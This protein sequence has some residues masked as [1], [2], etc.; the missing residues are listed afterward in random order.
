MSKTT[1]IDPRSSCE[2]GYIKNPNPSPVTFSWRPG[3]EAWIVYDCWCVAYVKIKAICTTPNGS[4]VTID[5][6]GETHCVSPDILF[7][8][9]ED[10]ANTLLAARKEAE[11]APQ[12]EPMPEHKTLTSI[13]Y[14]RMILEH[15]I[16][17][18]IC[19]AVAVLSEHGRLSDMSTANMKNYLDMAENLILLMKAYDDEGFSLYDM[20]DAILHEISWKMPGVWL[21]LRNAMQQGEQEKKEAFKQVIRYT[22]VVHHIKG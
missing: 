21:M 11:S 13:D 9:C 22:Q 4:T 3:D 20:L 14:A 7:I 5:D 1:N 6:D 19:T 15:R 12:P 10:A 17:I 8:S 16:P 2:S 18:H